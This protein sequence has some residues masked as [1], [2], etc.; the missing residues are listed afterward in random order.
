MRLQGCHFLKLLSNLVSND[1]MFSMFACQTGE[2]V[3]S[4]LGGCKLLRE[5]AKLEKDTENKLAM[6]ELARKFEKL[7]HGE[8]LHTLFCPVKVY[9]GHLQSGIGN[10]P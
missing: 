5:L 4:A 7:A 2:S 1:P 6:K 8:S 9:T 10:F 3:L